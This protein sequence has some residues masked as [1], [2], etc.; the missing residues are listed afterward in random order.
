MRK[1]TESLKKLG[2]ELVNPSE[3][4]EVI[5]L[6]KQKMFAL[7]LVDSLSKE[8]EAVCNHVRELGNVPLILVVN[9]RKADWKR[10]HP[11]GADGYLPSE[12]GR[13]EL[14]A[15]LRAMHRRF[16]M[17]DRLKGDFETQPL[18]ESRDYR[19]EPNFNETLIPALQAINSSDSQ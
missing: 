15:R 16:F 1:I 3:M 17:A 14:T 11:L 10:L 6:L 8:T 5:A 2:I 7:V 19:L 9:S 4:T 13:N 18:T 12:A